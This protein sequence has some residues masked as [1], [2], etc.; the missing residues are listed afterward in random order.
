MKPLTLVQ[1]R[2]LTKAA[3]AMIAHTSGA[4]RTALT[5]ALNAI[6]P[7]ILEQATLARSR[8]IKRRNA[9]VEATRWVGNPPAWAKRLVLKYVP[10]LI[11][12]HWRRSAVSQATTGHCYPYEYRIVVTVGGTNENEHKV[13]VLHEIAHARTPG[14]NHDEQFWDELYRLCKAEG[15]VQ[16]ATACSTRSFTA[17]VR[18]A[19]TK[20]I[21]A[22]TRED[23]RLALFRG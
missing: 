9:A 15:L 22:R 3:G 18:R 21:I 12:F 8:E 23:H 1:Q 7:A 20:A 4:T 6:D 13:V 17:A 11:R 5:D 14:H 10:L 16:A 2:A 19:R